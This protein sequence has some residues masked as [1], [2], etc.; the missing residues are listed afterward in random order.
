MLFLLHG[1]AVV[2]WS[3]GDIGGLL[4]IRDLSL[5]LLCRADLFLGLFLIFSVARLLGLLDRRLSILRRRSRVFSS[6]DLAIL[7]LDCELGSADLL[8]LGLDKS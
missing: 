7:S 2:Y 8:G 3:V 6:V 5:S 4:R 1:L